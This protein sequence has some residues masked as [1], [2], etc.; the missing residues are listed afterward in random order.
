M[1]NLEEVKTYKYL[2]LQLSSSGSMN[3]ARSSL[4]SSAVKAFF[5]LR[6]SINPKHMKIKT[7]IR[8]F[9]SL[10][11]PILLYGCEITNTFNIT[12]SIKNNIHK[13]FDKTN[14]WEQERLHL[15]FCR[16]ILGVG[17][18]TT[19]MAIYGELGRYPIFIKAMKQTWKFYNRCTQS[20]Q[21]SLIFDAFE[22]QKNNLT[23][24]SWLYFVKFMSESMD[25]PFN[26]TELDYEL[27]SN[28]FKV[29]FRDYWKNNLHNDVRNQGYGNKLRTYRKFKTVFNQ[30][31]YLNIIPSFE[32]RRELCK[33]RVSNHKLQIE[34]GRHNNI[35]IENRLCATCQEIEDEEHF[36]TKCTKYNNMR[37]ELYS[38]VTNVCPNFSSLPNED[39]FVY[40]LT[41][42]N[43]IVV[44]K[45][46][47][48]CFSCSNEG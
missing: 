27:A 26:F 33:F 43:E 37:R 16:L 1:N 23:D 7:I 5:K 17:P 15:Q 22:E 31:S 14:K 18:K 2:G 20:N 47:K 13:V 19:N 24:N 28:N 29:L 32:T 4:Y 21:N 38:S 36:L 12:N 10:I 41:C 35:A 46:G 39:R 6:R 40:L 8:I 34:I 25:I 11:E 9:E 45:V 48:I 3:V 30:E 44:E 42:D